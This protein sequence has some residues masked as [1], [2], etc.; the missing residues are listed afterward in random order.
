MDQKGDCLSNDGSK[1]DATA[2]DRDA[3]PAAAAMCAICVS[4]VCVIDAYFPA[5]AILS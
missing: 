4:T 5:I 2:Q 1:F 3:K